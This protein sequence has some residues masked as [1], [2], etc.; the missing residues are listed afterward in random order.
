MNTPVREGETIEG[1]RTMRNRHYP[2]LK[3]SSKLKVRTLK[4]APMSAV[5]QSTFRRECGRIIALAQWCHTPK[6]G[7]LRLGS[8]AWDD[9]A[10]PFCWWSSSR[11][12]RGLHV[13]HHRRTAGNVEGLLWRQGAH[14][15]Q[16]AAHTRR[17][18]RKTR[19]H[20]YTP[21]PRSRGRA[22]S[23][24]FGK[25]CRRLT[26]LCTVATGLSKKQS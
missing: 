8:A 22:I 3:G 16:P 25:A 10:C 12:G 11:R 24:A 13:G 18:S 14:S 19:R 1:S 6:L 4:M 7:G 15:K 9:N 23:S 2:V 21:V 20:S 17:I 5:H 26:A